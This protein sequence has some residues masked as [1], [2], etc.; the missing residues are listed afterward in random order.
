MLITLLI[1]SMYSINPVIT[2][3]FIFRSKFPNKILGWYGY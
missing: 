3:R 2:V 1:H